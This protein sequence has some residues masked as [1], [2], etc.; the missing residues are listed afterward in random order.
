[1]RSHV[2]NTFHS[3]DSERYFAT[4]IQ[5]GMITVSQIKNLPVS[6]LCSVFIKTD[7]DRLRPRDI[8]IFRKTGKIQVFGC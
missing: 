1:M 7:V 3:L 4:L 5:A 8:I 6:K 2:E